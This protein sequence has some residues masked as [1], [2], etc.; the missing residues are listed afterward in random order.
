MHP[1]STLSHRVLLMVLSVVLQLLSWRSRA[2]RSSYNDYAV[3]SSSRVTRLLRCRRVARFGTAPVLRTRMYLQN[4]ATS[5]APAAAITTSLT[6]LAGPSQDRVGNRDGG[7]GG[8]RVG[9]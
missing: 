7:G 3:A 1:R 5:A 2:F 6:D 4:R 8:G 9:L